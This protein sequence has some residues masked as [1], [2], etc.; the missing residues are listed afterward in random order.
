MLSKNS[1]GVNELSIKSK[2]LPTNHAI[3]KR[4]WEIESL[5]CVSGKKDIPMKRWRFLF[6]DIFEAI[7]ETHGIVFRKYCGDG[8]VREEYRERERERERRLN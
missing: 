8:L 7:S 5:K 4:E 6:S 2:F 3:R 1:K